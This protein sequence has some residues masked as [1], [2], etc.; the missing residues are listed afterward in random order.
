MSASTISVKLKDKPRKVIP[1]YEPKV[2]E[3]KQE[4]LNLARDIINNS[5]LIVFTLYQKPNV[6]IKAWEFVKYNSG[7]EEIG[8]DIKVIKNSFLKIALEE[9]NYN[10]LVPKIRGAVVV[11]YT[12]N[13]P[14]NLAKKLDEIISTLRKEKNIKEDIPEILFGILEGKVISA[15][16]VNQLSKIPSKEVLLA[17]L[18]GTLK[19]PISKLAST[20]NT[21]ILKLLWALQAVKEKKG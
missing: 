4:K 9:K 10:E 1:N 3:E 5:K 15:Q 21:I 8:G 6:S 12:K 16:D 11:N 18:A 19:A 7:I 13:D 20:L 14:I 2:N 17:Q